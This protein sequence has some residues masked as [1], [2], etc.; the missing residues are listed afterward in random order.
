MSTAPGAGGGEDRPH[1]DAAEDL[2][3][4]RARWNTLGAED[5]L[6]AVL[7][8]RGK[9]GGR[10]DVEEFLATGRQEIDAVWVELTRLGLEP[11][12]GSA[13]DFGC[14]AGRLVHGLAGHVERVTGLD[15][16]STMVRAAE[17]INPHGDRCRFIVNERSDLAVLEGEQF[18]VVYSCRVLQHMPQS[19]SHA[20]IQE[21][22]RA[23]RPGSGILVFQI[24]SEPAG[25]LVGRALRITPR[26][27]VDRVRR[28]EMHGTTPEEVR[29]L[30][31]AAGGE[32]IDVTQDASAGPHW[33]SF[34][35]TIRLPG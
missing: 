21:L 25:T 15:L 11:G 20:Y 17:D 18:D 5:P 22:V 26:W 8:D 35:Y 2:R 29:H 9:G 7:T 19:L 1:D 33:I 13:L 6:W 14:G 23:V 27:L 24:P 16:A 3:G 30:V 4:V 34:R 28:M 32:V 31:A 12:T 10:W